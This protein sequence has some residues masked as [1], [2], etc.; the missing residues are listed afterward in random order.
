MRAAFLAAIL[1]AFLPVVTQ[2]AGLARGR[3]F[4][5]ITPA[6]PTQMAGDKY[7]KLVLS[8]AETF[9]GQFL[10]EWLGKDAP[11]GEVRTVISVS[12]SA[13]ENSGMTLAKDEP[14]QEFH[15]VFLEST[16]ENAAGPMLRHEIAHTVLATAYPHP[17]RLPPWVEEGIA[18]RYDSERLISARRQ[19]VLFWMRTGEF[20]VLAG[21]FNATDIASIDDA[22]YAAAE[23]LVAYL[24]TRGDKQ[25]LLRFAEE[26]PRIGWDLALESHYGIDSQGQLQRAWQSWLGESVR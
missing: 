11:L 9:R 3:N 15:N 20:P 13:T 8:R 19:E 26:G 2:A 22:G 16:A 21:L 18:S 6:T 14:S 12:F 1:A 7:A 10:E 17:N 24:L 5:V 23:S 25:T 4:S